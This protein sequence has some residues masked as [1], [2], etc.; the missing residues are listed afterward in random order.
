MLR[1]RHPVQNRKVFNSNSNWTFIALNLPIQ[2]GLKVNQF[3]NPETEER[4]K[5][6]RE[7]QDLMTIC[8][9]IH[10]LHSLIIHILS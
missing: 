3:Q 8:Y 10:V 2:R 4:V 6:H 1:K 9:V 5:H 7:R